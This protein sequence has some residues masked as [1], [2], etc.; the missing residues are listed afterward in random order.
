MVEVKKIGVI[1]SKTEH[2]FES[3]GVLNPG[4]IQ[5]GNTIKMIY[6][7][8]RNGNFSTLGYCQFGGP[9]KL[10]FRDP[11]PLLLPE[12][13]YE[14]QGVED[15]RIVKIDATY[16]IT[17]TGYDGRN[18]LGC[19]ATSKDLKRF[20]KIGI[21]TPATSLHTYKVVLENN[22]EISP[23]Y[24]EHLQTYI[25]RGLIDKTKFKVWD[26]DLVLFPEKINGHFFMLHRLLPGIQ[27]VRF[28]EFSDL[29]KD[30]WK[31][32]LFSLDKYVLLN[33]L[34]DFENM[35][36]GGGAPPVK[37]SSGWLLIN[38]GVQSTPLG[39]A[40]HATAVL[41]DL[42]DPTKVIARMPS[43]LFSPTEPYEKTGYINNVCF[44][45]GTAVFGEDLYIYYGAADNTVALAKTNLNGLVAHLLKFPTV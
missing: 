15:P 43:P 40:Y 9:S 28:K 44:P 13:S 10:D 12:E 11:K 6:R 23:K 14:K 31:E 33:P 21:V 22:K 42:N 18:A 27:W 2:T 17:Y 34:Y 4:V 26:K 20:Q 39:R 45:T 24:A 7:A 16:Y 5:E 32:Y 25:D 19:I 35:H 1:L 37:T 3:E 41:L 29:T 38:H 8:F 36:I 30:F